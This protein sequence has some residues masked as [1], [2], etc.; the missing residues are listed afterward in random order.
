METTIKNM[1]YVNF[2][3]FRNSGM[4]VE[5]HTESFKNLLYKITAVIKKHGKLVLKYETPKMRWTE[6][7][8]A[9]EKKGYSVD[10]YRDPYIRST[11]IWIFSDL[12]ANWLQF[13]LIYPEQKGDA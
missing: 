11:L 12:I 2:D 9:F 8:K 3:Y 6:I 10:E 7:K 4:T 13:D 1:S 5:F